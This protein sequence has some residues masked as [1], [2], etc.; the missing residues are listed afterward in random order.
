MCGIAGLA[1]F[2]KNVK[3]DL[4]IVKNMMEILKNRG[5]D[6]EGTWEDDE[7]I[8][9][10][11]RLIVLDPAGGIQPMIRKRGEDAYVIVYNGELYNASELREELEKAG[12]IFSTRNSDT[13]VVLLAYMNWK[14]KCLERFNGIYALAIW[15]MRNKT[16]FL[17]R[18]RVGVK[19]LFYT[20]KNGC[21]IFAS[22]IKALLV[23]PSVKAEIDREGL[24]EILALG[25]G[26]TP[27]HGVFRNIKELKPASYMIY[28]R[29]GIKEVSY[30]QLPSLPVS[31]DIEEVAFNI[32]N[33][34]S[35]AVEKQL[36]ADV[37]ICTLLSGGL[38][39][40]I[41][42]ALTTECAGKEN[43]LAD[44]S[45]FS[46]DYEDN[47][48][49]FRADGFEK[50][51]DAKWALKVADFLKI[52]HNTVLLDNRELFQA[53]NQALE[54]NDLPGMADI[55][56]S[57]YLFCREIKKKA[58]VALSGE[59]ADEVFGGYPWFTDSAMLKTEVFP[60]I[61]M[62]DQRSM[63]LR[64]QIKEK[65]NLTE[66]VKYRYEEAIRK[67]PVVYEENKEEQR[68]LEMAY[69]SIHHFMPTLLNRKDRMSMAW[70]LEIRVP[71]SDHRLIEYVWNLPSE[72]KFYKNMPKGILRYAV[73]GLLPEDILYRAK[74]PY[75]KTHHPIY[76]RMVKREMENILKNPSSP[77][78][79]LLD[80]DKLEEYLKNEQQF[81]T[82]PWFGQLMRDAQYLAYMIQ[83][84]RW[85]NKYNVNILID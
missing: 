74:T 50:D 71:F 78:L 69:L 72:I 23:H 20:F 4:N 3:G 37:N 7:V 32:R 5:P 11:R 79:F 70:G 14:E 83:L 64:P 6:A 52:R 8:L 57:L 63:F 68:L 73:K 31:A 30:W 19:P 2:N 42:T 21:L 54:A 35:D 75:P 66:Y 17:A 15:D 77:I 16:L 13:E 12:Y 48:V 26:R 24:C 45:S 82:L 1:S 46:V 67:V 81:F 29:Q 41:I 28:S 10:H 49:Y 62:L 36:N 85:I 34:L 38:D 61:R 18:D 60:W 9:G 53:L 65:I 84:N 39:S 25:P 22:E 56:A 51:V 33:I 58:T 43:Y 55:D 47:Q 44:I 59:C 80:R 27:G 76:Y 40:S